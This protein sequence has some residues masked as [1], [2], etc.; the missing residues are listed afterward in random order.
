MEKRIIE[1]NDEEIKKMVLEHWA[2][3]EDIT[4]IG[5]YTEHC[6]LRSK[7][8]M[9]F[10]GDNIKLKKIIFEFEGERD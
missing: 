7:E 3:D 5:F 6:G 8:H 2:D 9:M 4:E 1:L 10:K